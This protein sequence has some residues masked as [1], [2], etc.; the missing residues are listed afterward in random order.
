[1]GTAPVITLYFLSQSSFVQ[2]NTEI[3]IVEFEKTINKLILHRIGN[4]CYYH[5]IGKV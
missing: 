4:A 3:S 5:I 2:Q 1:M